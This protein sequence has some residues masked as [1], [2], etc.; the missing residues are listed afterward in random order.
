MFIQW[1][2]LLI[3]IFFLLMNYILCMYLH[4]MYIR[5]CIP[6]RGVYIYKRFPGNYIYL[7][8]SFDD[9]SDVS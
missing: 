9:I 8:I 1:N 4:N 3:N 7:I 5:A 2:T 6:G